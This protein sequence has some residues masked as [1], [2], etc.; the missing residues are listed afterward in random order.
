MAT[1]RDLAPVLRQ[2]MGV[3]R[4][5][6]AQGELIRLEALVAGGLGYEFVDEND[7]TYTLDIE[8]VAADDFSVVYASTSAATMFGSIAQQS[9]WV[10][11]VPTPTL[12][13]TWPSYGKSITEQP[14]PVCECGKEKHGFVA[15][16]SWCA[17]AGAHE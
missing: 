12:G 3:A 10:N 9:G 6:W 1:L 11:Y 2:G 13:T 5:S 8:D 14:Q 7:A 15:H 16:S 4:Q 17:K